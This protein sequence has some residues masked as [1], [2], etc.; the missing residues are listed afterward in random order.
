MLLFMLS[1]TGWRLNYPDYENAEGEVLKPVYREAKARG[2]ITS[3]D[4]DPGR[5][6]TRSELCRCFVGLSGL[7]AAAEMRGIFRCGFT[8]EETIPEADL[9]YVAIAKGL[10]VVQGDS[11]GAF[12]PTDGATRQ[13]LAL[14]LY[15]YLSR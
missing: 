12:R 15:R 3:T 13:E 7:T 8:D 1:A 2:F 9:G 5:T 11:A 10:G 4:Q 6:V 14:M